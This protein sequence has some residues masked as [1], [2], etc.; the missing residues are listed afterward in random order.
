MSDSEM[1]LI[2]WH[3]S[4]EDYL[5]STGERAQC[6]SW[7]HKRAEEHYSYSKAY[8]D[9]PVIVLSGLTG[10]CSVGTTAIFG[11]NNAQTASTLLG[12][13]SL[14]VSILNTI[15]SYFAWAKRAEGHRISSIQYSQLY[16]GLAVELKLPR[17]ERRSPTIMLKDVRDAYDRLQEI[18][19]LLP[20][21]VIKAFQEKFDKY[22]DISKPEDINGLESIQIYPVA[23]NNATPTKTF[24]H[25]RSE[26]S[27]FIDNIVLTHTLNN[28]DNREDGAGP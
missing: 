21:K 25:M 14:L 18:S 17:E 4:L 23:P 27:K 10:F 15:G 13:V 8:I 7:C 12:A 16:R 1:S 20:K 6:L 11:S 24:S 19:P 22:K 5:A 2:T 26:G 3:S 9:L 28:V